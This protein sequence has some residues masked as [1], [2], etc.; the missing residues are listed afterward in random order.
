[1]RPP[2]GSYPPPWQPA[3][4]TAA[5]SRIERATV[6][7]VRV[8]AGLGRLRERLRLAAAGGRL[9]GHLRHL[10]LRG[11]RQPVAADRARVVS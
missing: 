10:R 3:G 11:F 4:P 1:M 9:R 8:G 6:L 2:R 5:L 7:T